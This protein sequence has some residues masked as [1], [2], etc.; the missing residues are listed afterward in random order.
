MKHIITS[1][2]CG[3]LA[4]S[5][6][7][8][9]TTG[10]QQDATVIVSAGVTYMTARAV[11]KNP[12]KAESLREAADA[13]DVLADGVVNRETVLALLTDK[14]GSK[15]PALTALVTLVVGYFAPGDIGLPQNSQ[16]SKL[17]KTVA[18]AI[19]AGLPAV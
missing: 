12:A 1:I 19:R 18:D 10:G 14:L 7:S 5:H 8:C 9:S 17:A 2:L 13:L 3:I 15:D 16:Y 11:Q 4:F 6:T